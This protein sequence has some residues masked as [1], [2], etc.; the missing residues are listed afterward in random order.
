MNI[1]LI[2]KTALSVLILKESYLYCRYLRLVVLKC[3]KKI[4]TSLKEEGKEGCK[5]AT[6][7]SC[8][9]GD[10]LSSAS[11]DGQSRAE[12]NPEMKL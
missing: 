7:A 10:R 12:H 1:L 6:S 4:N 5:G 8:L 2:I 11:R 9:D 3:K